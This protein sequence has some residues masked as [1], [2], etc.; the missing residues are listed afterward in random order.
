MYFGAPSYLDF[1]Q[2][3]FGPGDYGPQAWAQ[4]LPAETT[5]VQSRFQMSGAPNPYSA[6][7]ADRASRWEQA[8]DNYRD[9]RRQQYSEV[10]YDP[11]YDAVALPWSVDPITPTKDALD[12]L[13]GTQRRVNARDMLEQARQQTPYDW[14]NISVWEKAAN[15]S[16]DPSPYSRTQVGAGSYDAM[17]KTIRKHPAEFSQFSG[18]QGIMEWLRLQDPKS[19]GLPGS[20][21]PQMGNLAIGSRMG[22]GGVGTG[23]FAPAYG[24]YQQPDQDTEKQGFIPWFRVTPTKSAPKLPTLQGDGGKGWAPAN[25][26]QATANI[27]SSPYWANFG[28]LTPTNSPYRVRDEYL[29]PAN[30]DR[31]PVVPGSL[32]SGWVEEPDLGGYARPAR[33][34]TPTEY[35][36]RD[37]PWYQPEQ[38]VGARIP[39]LMKVANPFAPYGYWGK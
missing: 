34:L 39:R 38:T 8:K 12:R 28:P 6:F 21:S 31:T 2:D 3:I 5:P 16:Q 14:Y 36:L 22:M 35:T 30:P 17:A 19:S 32:G 11:A 10:G 26:Q 15:G 1:A 9:Y 33:N 23:S 24:G 13:V 37:M 4:F 18:S 27:T 7:A 29:I 20:N 25:A